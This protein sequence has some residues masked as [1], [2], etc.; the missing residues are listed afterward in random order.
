MITDFNP[1]AGP[2]SSGTTIIIN[3]T[4][5]GT[6]R[7][8][9][10]SV[11]VGNRNC[12][13]DEYQPGVW[14]KCT[15]D[16]DTS[17]NANRNES[18]T[19]RVTR[20]SGSVA[21][22]SS[23]Q[24]QFITPIIQS[25]SP[26]YGPVSG[27]TRIRIQGTNFDIGNKEMTR[28]IMRQ[29]SRKKRNTCPDVNCNITSIINTEINCVTSSINDTDCVRNVIVS[30]NGASFSNTSISYQYRPDP[31]FYSISPMVTIPAGGI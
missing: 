24:Y 27:G 20:S 1:K 2:P 3:G 19:V 10:E 25:V 5:L 30:V 31:T 26:T 9:I 8:D 29:S 16:P 4:D 14:I 15:I 23:T 12:I 6:Q 21:V 13:V 28:V 11:M 7:S 22:N 18:I 17:D